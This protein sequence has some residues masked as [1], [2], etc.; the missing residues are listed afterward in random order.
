MAYKE[1]RSVGWF[2][3]LGASFRGLG[4]G[5]VMIIA[6]TWLLWWNEGNFVGT[7]DALREAQAVTVEL[8]D[9]TQLDNSKNGRLVHAA[10]P[11]ETQDTLT[12][13]VFG[14]SIKAIRLERSVEFYQWVE[15][16]RSETKQKLGGGEETVTTY[17]YEPTWTSRPVDSAQFKDPQARQDH[18]NTVLLNLG[19]FKAQAAN[20]TFGAYR[21]PDFMISSISGAAP[22]EAV[23]P[24]EMKAKLNKELAPAGPEDQPAAPPEPAATEEAAA[25]QGEPAATPEPA[26]ETAPV[27]NM[28]HASGNTVL[29]S[30]T[31]EAPQIGD[32]RVTFR[33]TPPGPVSFLARCSGDTFEPYRAKNG[34]TVSRFA[35][36]THSLETM[37]GDAHSANAATTWMLRAAGA[38]LV[39]FGLKT[40][41]APL[42]VLFSFIPLLGRLVGAGSGLASALLGLA[43][44]LVVISIAW[45]RFRPLI[46]GAMLV[47]AGVLLTLCFRGRAKKSKIK[48]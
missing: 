30:A 17:D 21:L 6:G 48:Y 24:Q 5:L 29:L 34:Q 46:G 9:P 18:Q 16:S 36:G 37:Y 31:P 8:G 13:P 25:P 28:V 19:D 2:D 12:D 15:E 3:R 4:L 27:T 20:V 41:L 7:G 35:M 42:S 14:L 47:G 45:L 26:Q 39:I 1:V 23:I 33:E 11:V 40:V 10:G 22:L 38:V 32:V 43:W 44:S